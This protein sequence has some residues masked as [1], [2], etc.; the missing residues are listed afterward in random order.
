VEEGK[1]PKR[2]RKGNSD[3]TMNSMESSRLELAVD[4]GKNQKGK[5]LGYTQLC[6]GRSVD[7]GGL[8]TPER[9]KLPKREGRSQSGGCVSLGEESVKSRAGKGG[10]DKWRWICRLC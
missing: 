5:K 7:G 4:N 8:S 10:T 3:P 2:F 1:N 6:L 9:G